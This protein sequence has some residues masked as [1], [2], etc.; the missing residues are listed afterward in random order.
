[1]PLDIDGSIGVR[2][3]V[4]N[5]NQRYTR[6]QQ[7]VLPNFDMTGAIEPYINVNEGTIANLDCCVIKTY[8]INPLQEANPTAKI[9]PIILTLALRVTLGEITTESPSSILE[10]PTNQCHDPRKQNYRFEQR[11]S[12]TNFFATHDLVLLLVSILLAGYQ[13]FFESSTDEKDRLRFLISSTGLMSAGIPS[14]YLT[15]NCSSIFKSNIGVHLHRRV[16][17][18]VR[19]KTRCS[20]IEKLVNGFVGNFWAIASHT[21]TNLSLLPYSSSKSHGLKAK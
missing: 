16:F 10:V 19:Y 13:S 12:G 20:L 2:K 15:S 11:E 5:S 7:T 14:S 6:C 17:A 8:N 1:M 3:D 4:I 18:F 21:D 9:N